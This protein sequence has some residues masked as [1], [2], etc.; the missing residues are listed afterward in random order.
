M[1]KLVPTHK[2]NIMNTHIFFEMANGEVKSLFISFFI[3]IYLHITVPVMHFS[4]LCSK[5]NV[6]GIT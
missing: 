1:N 2:I 4:Q 5:S 6:Y 3:V